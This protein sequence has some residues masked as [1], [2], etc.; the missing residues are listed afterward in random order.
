[1]LRSEKEDGKCSNLRVGGN[2]KKLT[3]RQ[4]HKYNV[5]FSQF[6]KRR[7]KLYEQSKS[8]HILSALVSVEGLCLS[9]D[10]DFKK[11]RRRDFGGYKLINMNDIRRKHPSWD[12]K[13]IVI[14][15]EQTT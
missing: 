13:Y 2:M 5:M 6:R 7:F 10:I 4:M 11:S 15:R 3:R 14:N 9:I 8:T 1:M 12:L